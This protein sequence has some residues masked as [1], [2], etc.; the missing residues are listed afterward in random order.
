MSPVTQLNNAPQDPAMKKKNYGPLVLLVTLAF[1]VV[2]FYGTVRSTDSVDTALTAKNRVRTP[3]PE[4]SVCG[5]KRFAPNGDV[6]IDTIT[7]F[8]GKKPQWGLVSDKHKG[9]NS[10]EYDTL[11]GET[12]RFFSDEGEGHMSDYAIGMCADP[13]GCPLFR[14]FDLAPDQQ[15]RKLL[16]S[17]DIKGGFWTLE[18]DLSDD[19]G[20]GK[21]ISQYAADQGICEWG[22]SSDV[23]D[24]KIGG[25]GGVGSAGGFMVKCMMPVGHHFAFGPGQSEDC[26][27]E[28]GNE[29]TI[30]QSD[31]LQIYVDNYNIKVLKDCSFCAVKDYDPLTREA[32]DITK[33]DGAWE[34]LDTIY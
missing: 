21:T 7:Q 1:A 28:D 16:G 20:K 11:C 15:R 24:H 3:G 30:P 8:H 27:D 23:L 9:P 19:S 17:G 22:Y 29:F 26:L 33:C 2:T 10:E 12:T 25:E 6:P 32:P 14:S 31:V 4:S 34:D 13:K 5:E 18:E